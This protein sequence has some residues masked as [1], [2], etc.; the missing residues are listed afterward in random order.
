MD[1]RDTKEN[2]KFVMAC[3][4]KAKPTECFVMAGITI[5]NEWRRNRNLD[6]LNPKS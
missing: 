5:L 3:I 4:T 6:G 1:G 2:L